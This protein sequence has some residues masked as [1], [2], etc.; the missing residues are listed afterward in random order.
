VR[1]RFA[2]MTARSL[3]GGFVAV[4]S[5]ACA[6]GR[7]KAGQESRAT[8]PAAGPAA[9][10]P[11]PGALT[12]PIEQ[13]TGDE[14][15]AFT[16]QLQYGGGGEH[17]R[18]CRG[19]PGC[20]GANPQETT[21][22]Q[23]DGVAGDDSLSAAG[24]PAYGVIAVRAVNRGPYADS[25]YNTRPGDA[26]EN[27]LIVIPV[28]NSATASWRLEELTTTAGA[29]THRTLATGTLREC[30]RHT[31]QRG[32]RADFKTCDEA[33]KLFP[34]SSRAFLQGDV[35]PPIWFGCAVGCCTADPPGVRG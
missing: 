31:F 5:V 12:K 23:V 33:A 22:V 17:P 6:K 27:Y 7:E 15:Y 9:P 30:P 1:L 11:A 3:I 29:R 4:A 18:R 19:R 16:R 21:R 34:A 32:P 20:G 13:Y 14:L 8:V 35:D 2:G 25:A 24:L 26:Y 10:L 28:A